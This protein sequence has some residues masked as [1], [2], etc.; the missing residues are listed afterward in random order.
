MKHRFATYAA[1]IALSAATAVAAHAASPSNPGQDQ[2]EN[3][4]TAQL[5]QQQLPADGRY[6]AATGQSAMRSLHQGAM[7]E[8]IA[9]PPARDSDLSVIE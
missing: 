3:Q 1:F 8:Q 4:I 7:Q 6:D 9:E 2:S 5:N